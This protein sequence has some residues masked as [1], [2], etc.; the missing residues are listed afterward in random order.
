MRS[1]S[2]MLCV[3]YFSGCQ[4]KPVETAP[5][6]K[7]SQATSERRAATLAEQKLCSDQSKK[8]YDESRLEP[9][10]K[11]FKTISTDY[12]SHYDPVRNVCFVLLETTDSVDGGQ[13]IMT[14]YSV[15]DAFERKIYGHYMWTSDKK[16]KYWEVSPIEC[17]VTPTDSEKTVCKTE[18]EFKQLVSVNYGLGF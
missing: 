14:V 5:M 4:G 17:E 15:M 13:N 1:F 16:K 7:S 8:A 9:D 11:G 3:L 10:V 2:I 18:D 6:P 12:T